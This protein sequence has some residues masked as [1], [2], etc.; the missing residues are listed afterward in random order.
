MKRKNCVQWEEVHGYTDGVAFLCDVSWCYAPDGSWVSPCII[1]SDETK[2]KNLLT[3]KVYDFDDSFDIDEFVGHPIGDID[4]RHASTAQML[5]HYGEGKIGLFA[6][7]TLF[8]YHTFGLSSPPNDAE[9]FTH[10]YPAVLKDIPK[11]TTFF[12][13]QVQKSFIKQQKQVAK[14]KEAESDEYDDTRF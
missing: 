10:I 11:L 1:S 3:N 4:Y 5:E 12:E 2:I 6:I 9:T 14:E 7:K 13:K 8:N